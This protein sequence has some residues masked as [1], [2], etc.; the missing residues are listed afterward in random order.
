MKSH[1]AVTV[2]K[3]IV[4]SIRTGELHGRERLPAVHGA[5]DRQTV[6]VQC[7]RD[8]VM[9]REALERRP[10][11]SAPGTISARKSS[12]KSESTGASEDVKPKIYGIKN[13]DT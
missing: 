7:G 11:S 12:D 6:C 5:A 4:E 1:G 3:D 2:G 13:C 8:R 9:P 10:C